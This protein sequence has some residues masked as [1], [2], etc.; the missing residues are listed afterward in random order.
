MAR[1]TAHSVI[2][3]R[4]RSKMNEEFAVLK[5]MIP[6][7]KDQEMHK[8]AILSAGIEYLRYLEQCVSN[9]KIAKSSVS[10]PSPPTLKLATSTAEEDHSDPEE[11]EIDEDQEMEDTSTET[12]VSASTY[13]STCSV[14]DSPALSAIH[15]TSSYAS[16]VATLPSPA[17]G[18]NQYQSSYAHSA[19]ASPTIL[20]N[21]AH[22]ADHEATAALLMLN[23]DRRNPKG[24]SPSGRSMSVQDLLSSA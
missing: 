13:R 14:S 6:A 4:R 15:T 3:R 24:I 19:S 8:L 10:Q 23:K 1:K 2:E 11:D 5:N 9:L 18:P 21:S 16:S 22:D 7:C 12:P 20:P 17:F